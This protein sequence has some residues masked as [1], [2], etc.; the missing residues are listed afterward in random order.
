MED[1][2]DEYLVVVKTGK[3]REKER[4]TLFKCSEI[5]DKFCTISFLHLI[6][7]LST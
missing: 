1:I 3:T 7:F 2:F 5:L 6:N 4:A